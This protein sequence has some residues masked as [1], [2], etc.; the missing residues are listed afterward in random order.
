MGRA[1]TAISSDEAAFW[2]PAALASALGRRATVYRGSLLTGEATA[3]SV[4]VPWEGVGAFAV[5]YLLLDAGSQE[6]RNDLGEALGSISVWNQAVVGSF[7]ASLPGGIDAGINLKLVQFRVSCRGRCR[8]L[9]TTSS[10]YAADIGIQA[11]PL[12]SAPLRLGA[13]IA[14]AGTAFEISNE[15]RSD[16]LPTRIRIAA[17]YPLLQRD[18]EDFPYAL[19]LSLEGEDRLRNLGNASLFSGLLV[20]AAGSFSARAGYIYGGLD[21]TDGAS[22]GVGFSF[23]RFSLHLAKSLARSVVTGETEPVHVSFSVGF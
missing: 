8:E 19:W 12:K 6:L 10:A 13:M 15:D 21:Q 2:N 14:H 20:T 23:D 18:G 1:M 16:P 22:A 7:A 11:Q 17:A 5:S 3:A 4:V 9:G